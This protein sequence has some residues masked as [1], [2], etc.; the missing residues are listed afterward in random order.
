[1]LNRPYCWKPSAGFV[2]LVAM[3]LPESAL[4]DATAA[5]IPAFARKYNVSCALCHSPIPRLTAFGESFAA[6]GFRMTPDEAPSGVTETGDSELSLLEDLPLAV[7]LDSY[8]NAYNNG[9]VVTDFE[10][11]YNLKLLSG[12]ALSDNISYYFYFFLFERGEVGGVEDAFLYFNDIAGSPIDVAVGQFQVSDPLFKRELRLEFQDYAIYR[13]RIGAQPTDLTY[14]RGIMAAGDFG[15]FTITGE[16]VNGNGKGGAQEN[17]RFDNDGN[18]NFF[19]HITRDLFDGFRVGAMGYRGRHE[20]EASDGAIR[21]NNVWMLGADAT[22]SRGPFELN[23]QYIH[24]EDDRPGFGPFDPTVQTD[25]GFV[26]LLYADPASKWYTYGLYNRVDSDQPLLSVRL[27]GP[28][29]ITRYETF[30]A[31]YGR[32]WRSNLRVF[33]EGTWDTQLDEGIW[34]LGLVTAF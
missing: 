27:G 1:M 29:G 13:A 6:N 10:V 26:E 3:I 34:T 14:D 30:S 8:M 9:S 4:A 24:R 19:G 21:S 5:H 12:G 25:G 32:L 23:A 31:G 18:K 11:P 33:I 17:R 20:G 22:V 2:L 28:S 15:G 16:I 7:R